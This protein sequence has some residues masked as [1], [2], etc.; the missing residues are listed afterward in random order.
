MYPS[1]A[2]TIKKNIVKATIDH[3]KFSTIQH[4]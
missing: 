2:K 4:D 1:K 3:L